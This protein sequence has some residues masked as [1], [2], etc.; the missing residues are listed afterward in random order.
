MLGLEDPGTIKPGQ[1]WEGT[2]QAELPSPVWGEFVWQATASGTGPSVTATTTSTHRPWLLIVLVVVLI[3]DLLI[4]AV[5]LL[6]RLV[7]RADPPEAQQF[8]DPFIDGSGGGSREW[9][10]TGFREPQLVS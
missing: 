10:A 6:M 4:L 1:T 3:L 2:V 9:G 5:R 8:D 7:R